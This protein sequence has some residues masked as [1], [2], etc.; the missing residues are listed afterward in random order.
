[1]TI[2]CKWCQPKWKVMA[3]FFVLKWLAYTI[4]MSREPLTLFGALQQK[5][6]CTQKT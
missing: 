4:N 2:L 5:F 1:M 3:E 6:N